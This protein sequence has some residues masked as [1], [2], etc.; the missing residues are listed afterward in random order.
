M[1]LAVLVICAVF[2]S[3]AGVRFRGVG[4]AQTRKVAN[5]TEI[6]KQCAL[7]PGAKWC[8]V[9]PENGMQAW[10]IAAYVSGDIVSHHICTSGRW[11]M[12]N[13]ASFGPVGMALDIGGNIG[14]NAFMLAQAGWEVHSFEPM[15]LNVQMMKATACQNPQIAQ[16]VHIHHMGL[17]AVNEH[18]EIMSNVTN[19]GD[20]VSRCGLSLGPVPSGYMVRQRFQVQRLDDVLAGMGLGSIQLVKMDVE[21]FECKVLQG[22]ES[23]LTQYK[24]RL[25][26][27]EVFPELQ[28]CTVEEYLAKYDRAGYTVAK[29]IDCMDPTMYHSGHVEDFYMCRKY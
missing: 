14:Y 7:P 15:D 2:T 3:A 26:Q 21:G 19:Q 11:E 20:G 12:K 28:G 27:T 25:I 13:T 1:V 6:R 9:Y 23:L 24:P 16:R 22:G 29:D 5:T 10:Q 17:G 8:T 4:V 18:C